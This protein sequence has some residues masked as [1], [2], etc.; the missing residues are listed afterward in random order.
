MSSAATAAIPSKVAMPA[1]ASRPMKS[2]IPAQNMPMTL[3]T[4]NSAKTEAAK[5]AL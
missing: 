1:V 4:P 5:V 3:M 2:E